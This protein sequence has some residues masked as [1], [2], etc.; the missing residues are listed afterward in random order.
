MANDYIKALLNHLWLYESAEVDNELKQQVNEQ[1][2]ALK[3]GLR[4]VTKKVGTKL[5][6]TRIK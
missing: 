2:R 1:I 3:P 6:I 5:E 4:F